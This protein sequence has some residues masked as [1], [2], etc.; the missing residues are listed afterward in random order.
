[1]SHPVI[2]RRVIATLNMPL[3]VPEFIIFVRGII[4][5]LTGNI[6][7]PT[8]Y[9][10]FTSDILTCTNNIDALEEAEIYVQTHASGSVAARDD[11]FEISKRD[12]RSIQIMVQQLANNN[13]ADAITII[14]SAGMGTKMVG[15][16]V[17]KVFGVK[18]TLISGTVKVFAPVIKKGKGAHYWFYT[19]DLVDFKNKIMAPSTT[20][21][22]IIIEG[23]L[24]STKYAF[25]HTATVPGGPNIE[26]G[27]EFITIL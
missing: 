25:F 12:M 10:A 17:K 16:S 15:G 13:I 19:T 20:K 14:R 7:I 27:P 21:A 26:E 2:N 11:A 9:P 22:S 1:M 24:E 6:H 3:S 8:P 4:L 23:L 18:N 5:K